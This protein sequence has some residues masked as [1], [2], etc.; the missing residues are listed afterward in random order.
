MLRG[1]ARSRS[2]SGPTT[3][4]CKA[5][6]SRW[7]VLL[8]HWPRSKFGLV[9]APPVPGFL[10]TGEAKL[11]VQQTRVYCWSQSRHPG[12]DTKAES[13]MIRYRPAIGGRPISQLFTRFRPAG[14]AIGR[15]ECCEV[16]SPGTFSPAGFFPFDFLKSYQ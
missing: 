1:S 3:R 2:G 12:S 15:L 10:S 8:R 4:D 13:G 5:E 7:T 16:D 6:E 9:A 11:V 14:R